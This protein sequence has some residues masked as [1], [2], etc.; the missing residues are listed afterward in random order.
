MKEL[1]YLVIVNFII[2][3]ILSIV[4]I[5][6]SSAAVFFMRYLIHYFFRN[7]NKDTSSVDSSL[8]LFYNDISVILLLAVTIFE[9]LDNKEYAFIQIIV[10]FLL[11]TISLFRFSHWTI[12]KYFNKE[13]NLNTTA[14]Q[15]T[16]GSLLTTLFDVIIPFI[17]LFNFDDGSRKEM[18]TF[19]IIALVINVLFSLY[20]FFSK[21]NINLV[22]FYIVYSASFSPVFYIGSAVYKSV[23]KGAIAI[24]PFL[25]VLLIF[26]TLTLIST[27][28][29]DVIRKNK[30]DKKR[31]RLM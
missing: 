24:F 30:R 2:F 16:E 6:I 13:T 21:K 15:A 9:L 11:L 12:L 27:S 20:R 17:L 5:A 31:E 14:S 10:I 25:I 1:F 26:F 23:Y 29:I 18:L 3:F 22:S 28:I 7:R 19:V 4:A 8:F